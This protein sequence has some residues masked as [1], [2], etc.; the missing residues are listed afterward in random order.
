MGNL[1]KEMQLNFGYVA[2]AQLSK[3]G[4]LVANTPISV[5]E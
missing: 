1:R 5:V 2:E 4:V 3:L